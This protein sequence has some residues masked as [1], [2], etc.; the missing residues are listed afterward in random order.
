MPALTAIRENAFL[1]ALV[2]G[3]LRAPR[4]V[5]GLQESDAELV[6]LPGTAGLLAL[7][8]DAIVEEIQTGLYRDPF[9][10]GW[11]TVMVNASD[12]AAVGAE[13]LGLLLN[14]TLPPD[15]DAAFLAELQRGIAMASRAAGLPVLGGDTNIGSHLQTCG[16]AVGWVPDGQPM[17]RLG[18][19]P[20]H[21]LYTTGPLGRG[22]AYACQALLGNAP[23]TSGQHGFQA[24][25][26][27]SPGPDLDFR[28]GPRLH[29]GQMLRPFASACMD[30]SDGFLPTLDQLMRLNG[31]G[32]EVSADLESYMDAA[33]ARVNQPAAVPPWVFLAGPHGEFELVFTVPPEREAAFLEAARAQDWRPLRLG[34]VTT[35]PVIR[36]RSG[37]RYLALDTGRIRNLFSEVGG[38]AA[39]YLCQLVDLGH[40]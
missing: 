21:L 38:D 14:E 7:T 35:Q 26:V 6:R 18:A 1:A 36:L 8:T 16:L 5:N 22:G 28:P 29:E 17:T 31:F 39:A 32:F 9:Q 3:F 10:I 4:Q 12:L 30:T 23:R 15:L 34:H 27:P 20:G 25:A 24:R 40:Q 33:A 19:A 11:M 2:G 37:D 13:P